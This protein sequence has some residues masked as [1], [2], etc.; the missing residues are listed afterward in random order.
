MNCTGKEA[1][2][3]KK[4]SKLAKEEATRLQKAEWHN[5]NGYNFNRD[6]MFELAIQRFDKALQSNPYDE[7]SFN[8]KGFSLYN[9]SI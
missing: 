4:K 5:L 2:S 9:L 7:K 8:G 3:S 6:G 1:K